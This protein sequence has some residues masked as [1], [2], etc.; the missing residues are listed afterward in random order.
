MQLL[1]FSRRKEN[2]VQLI[3]HALH[4]F[5]CIF[6]NTQ[7]K[8]CAYKSR[9]I[10]SKEVEILLCNCQKAIAILSCL[11]AVIFNYNFLWTGMILRVKKVQWHLSVLVWAHHQRVFQGQC[12]LTGS[13]FLTYWR[14]HPWVR[15]RYYISSSSL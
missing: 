7:Q 14:T 6:V 12:T 1:V 5:R 3:M 8:C 2:G 15:K 11:L 10:W 4:V 9:F 13:L